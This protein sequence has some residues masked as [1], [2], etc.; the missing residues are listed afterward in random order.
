M[1]VSVQ[2]HA[3]YVILKHFYLPSAE[4]T[5]FWLVSIERS[6]RVVSIPHI[7]FAF[8]SKNDWVMSVSVQPHA[9][10]MI[11]K[12]FY[13]PSALISKRSKPSARFFLA[14]TELG[15]KILSRYDRLENCST[16]RASHIERL[17]R[18]ANHS[19]CRKTS[20][21]RY[22]LKYPICRK[23]NKSHHSKKLYRCRSKVERWLCKGYFEKSESIATMLVL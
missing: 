18:W 8:L 19:L 20:C 21:F 13:L 15:C 14:K 7:V 17:Y 23:A 5:N 4:A 1:R 3:S 9:S 16:Y 12:H 2:P 11:L 10:Y 6:L 22:L